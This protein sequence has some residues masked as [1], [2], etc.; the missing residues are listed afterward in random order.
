MQHT[1]LIETIERMAH[2]N[3]GADSET[4]RE[5]A[6]LFTTADRPSV[7]ASSSRFRRWMHGAIASKSGS[8]IRHVAITD[9]WAVLNVAFGGDRWW[10]PEAWLRVFGPTLVTT[11]LVRL[12]PP[13]EF[14]SIRLRRSRLR[15]ASTYLRH[16]TRG[17]TPAHNC[18]EVVTGILR[19]GGHPIPRR[20]WTP[21]QLL[22]WFRHG[23]PSVNR[24]RADRG[25]RR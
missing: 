14:R 11:V 4:A 12:D 1:S 15:V 23:Q 25:A 13:V 22:E 2:R 20:I 10:A 8:D 24:T 5:V 7:M 6:V 21:A 9:G 18:L 3:A 17:R 19:D 16:L